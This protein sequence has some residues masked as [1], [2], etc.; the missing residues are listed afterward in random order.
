[1]M[2]KKS[3]IAVI[4]GGLSAL[5]IAEGLQRKGYEKVSVFEKNERLGGKLHSIDYKGRSYELGAIFGLPS[6][7]NLIELMKRLNIKAD[8]PRLSR[9]NYNSQGQRIMSIPKKDLRQFIEEFERLPEILNKYDSLKKPNIVD[10]EPSIMKPFLDWCEIYNFQVLKSVFIQYFTIFGLGD[11]NEVPAIYVLKTINYKDLMSFMDIPHIYTWKSGVSIL[12]ETLASRI[13]DISLSQEIKDIRI[14]QEDNLYIQT[15]YEEI[16]FDKVIITAP[17]DGF[18]HSDIWDKETKE[19]LETIK[20]QYFNVYTFIV[21]NMPRGCGCMLDNLSS[22]RQG[23]LT[24]WDSRWDDSNNEGLLTVYA[25]NPPGNSKSSALKYIKEDL[26]KMGIKN[27]KLYQV[28]HWN[29]SPHVESKSLERGF[30]N[31]LESIQGQKN[32]FLAGEIMSGV[33]IENSIRYS[34]YFLEKYF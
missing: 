4:G 16:A 14:S 13:K 11:I 29:H 28:K 22:S 10:L 3:K 30:Y 33:S 6:Y 2:E 26:E 5:L 34:E 23:H 9:T 19:Y 12:A 1:M 25:Y 7:S 24:I 15:P 32:I 27:P 8:G 17:L 20:Y 18:S 31:K 21:D